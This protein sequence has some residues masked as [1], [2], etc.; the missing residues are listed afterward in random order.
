MKYTISKDEAGKRLDIVI[1]KMNE[2]LTRSHVKRLID[3][4]HV[5]VN[6]EQVKASHRT[7]EGD[8]VEVTIPADLSS[9][10]KAENIPLDI[11]YEDDD[12][13]VVNKPRGMVSHPA[14]GNYGHTLANAL[15]YHNHG[16]PVYLAHRLDKDTSGLILAARSEAVRFT[17]ARQFKE[18]SVSKKYIAL[19]HGVMKQDAGSIEANIGRNPKNRQKMTVLQSSPTKKSRYALTLYKVLK[20]YKKYTLV[21]L[22]LKTGRTHQIRV[23]LTHIGHPLVGDQTYGKRSDELGLKGQFLHAGKIVFSHPVTKKLVKF[24][25]DLPEDLEKVL[26]ML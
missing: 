12:I 22:D 3:E 7:K 21:E 19:V 1:P 4:G 8:L 13:I 23:H 18:R 15:K 11:V 24:E 16:L 9:E 17:L 2:F 14:P 26:K 10:V 20:R 5:L 25:T 6:G